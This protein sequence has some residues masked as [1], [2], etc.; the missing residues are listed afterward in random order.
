MS[1]DGQQYNE[2]TLRPIKDIAVEQHRRWLQKAAT[3]Q[4]KGAEMT[5]LPFGYLQPAVAEALT[6][7]RDAAYTLLRTAVKKIESEIPTTFDQPFELAE[8]VGKR[9]APD[10]IL[11][12]L[13]TIYGKT[14]TV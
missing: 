7:D 12:L 1:K 11:T 6:T 14:H 10:S 8:S 2:Q 4:L 13:D 5:V 3:A 9:I